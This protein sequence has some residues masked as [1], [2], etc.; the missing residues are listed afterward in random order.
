MAKLQTLKQK[1]KQ[2]QDAST[3]TINEI[4]LVTRGTQTKNHLIGSL[5]LKQFLLEEAK[6]IQDNN[7]QWNYYY[8]YN[9][10]DLDDYDDDDDG[11]DSEYSGDADDESENELFDDYVSSS[12]SSEDQGEAELKVKDVV[13]GKLNDHK[14]QLQNQQVQSHHQNQNQVIKHEI[15]TS[16]LPTTTIPK[17][18]PLL[19][20]HAHSH[21]THQ[22]TKEQAIKEN[23]ELES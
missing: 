17:Q 14:E 20:P 5:N 7:N 6:S 13:D 2:K 21:H 4:N 15:R 16:I 18:R 10:D 9:D 11:E 8:Y 3:Q 1:D 19:L 23:H 12:S 22:Q